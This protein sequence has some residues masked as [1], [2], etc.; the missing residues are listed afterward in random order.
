[1]RR[2]GRELGVEAM[3]IYHHIPNKSAL[4]RIL[5]ERLLA[6]NSEVASAASPDDM[7]DAYCRGLRSSMLSRPNLVPLAATR[8]PRSLFEA[9]SSAAVRDR[10]VTF[11]FDQGAASWIFD[12]FLGF[13]VGHVL[14]EVTDGQ[15]S[16]DYDA[17][18]ETGLRFL[19]A[20]LR[21]ELGM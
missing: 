15:A 17:A 3:S 10:L 9:P 13:V 7:L 19:L 18:F 2:L 4:E 16:D 1:M 21:E 6:G 8:L 20:G 12:A 11:G 5:V 14:V